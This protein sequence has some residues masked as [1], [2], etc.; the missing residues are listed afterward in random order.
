MHCSIN[1]LTFLT[2]TQCHDQGAMWNCAADDWLI[3]KWMSKALQD[4]KDLVKRILVANPAQRLG[5]LK[6]GAADV[7]EHQWFAGF[8]WAAFS[9]RIMPAPYLPRA[10]SLTSHMEKKE[11]VSMWLWGV[12]PPQFCFWHRRQ[13]GTSRLCLN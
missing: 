1:I 13:C 10:S 12:E 7:K 4:L 6:G 9:K 2:V 11:H 3:K 5:A 8:D